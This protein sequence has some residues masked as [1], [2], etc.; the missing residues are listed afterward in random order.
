[1]KK[2]FL[3]GAF[4]AL[5]LVAYSKGLGLEEILN[6]VEAGSPEVKIKELD[7]KIK[8]KG[9]NKALKNLVLPPVN[10]STEEDWEI[11]KDEGIGFKEIEAYIPIFQGGRMMYGYKKAGKELDLAKE[12]QKLSVYKWQEQ[13]VSEYFDALNYRKQRE[14]TDKT[15]EA[16]QKQRARLDGLYKENKLIPKSEV[17]KVEADIENNR[18]QNLQ[19][20]QKERAAK[21][22]L[23][24]YL[25]YDL[26]KKIE[27]DEFDAIS[28]LENIGAIK[29]V[30][31]PETT[32]L[33]KRESLLVDVAEYDL[34]ITKADL[35]PSFYVKPSHKF[36]EKQGDK[37]VTTNE[38]MVEVGFRYRFEWGGTIDSVN[39]KEYALDQ[40][41][42]RYENN[43]RGI[44]LDM[45]NKLGE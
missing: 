39:Q 29:K 21:E 8:E 15:I 34:K 33:G 38:G 41:K 30:E 19:N 9:K 26:D 12:N 35:Y 16:L 18:A 36:K 20:I 1:M 37:L 3:V 7:V 5:S 42:I 4:L 40:A 17:L 27:L 45:R 25:G 10:L 22:T 14:I 28:Y 6:R 13:S 43:I 23:M 11:V 24:Q 32:T 44:D 31:A 2:K